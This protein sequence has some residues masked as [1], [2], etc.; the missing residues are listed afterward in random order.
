MKIGV[1]GTG[2]VGKK[3]GAGLI[4][5]GHEVKIGAFDDAGNEQAKKWVGKNGERA[6][7]GTFA[8]AAVFGELVLVAIAWTGCENA[9]KLAGPE[10]FSGKIV[11]DVTN[12]VI[13]EEEGKCP[14][15]VLGCSDSAGEHV[16]RWLPDA[17][18]V[19]AFNTVGHPHFINPDFP[20]VKPDMFICGNDPEAKKVVTGILESLGWPSV[21]DLGDITGARYMEPLG[22]LWIRYMFENN[23]FYNHAFKL[24]RK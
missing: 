18:V 8:E 13:Y 11:I 6:S 2:V 21:I 1:L 12:P 14:K 9:I 5:V 22:M 17:K 16:Q 23:G 3:I 20:E 19:K 7:A 15:L 4:K 24:L 10:N